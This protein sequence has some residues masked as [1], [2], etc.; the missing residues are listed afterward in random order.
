MVTTAYTTVYGSPRHIRPSYPSL[1]TVEGSFFFFFCFRCLISYLSAI[2]YHVQPRSL[3]S[4]HYNVWYILE[5]PP[6]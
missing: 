2:P 6:R 5:Y 1:L 3:S 4:W